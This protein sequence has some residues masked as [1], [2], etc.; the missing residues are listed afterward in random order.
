MKL[1]FK[2]TQRFVSGF[3]LLSALIVVSAIAFIIINNKFF[4]RRIL[5]KAKFADAIGLSPSTPVFFKGFKIGLITD[6]HLTTSNMIEANFE[7]YEEFEN[8]IVINSA[9]MKTVNPVTNASAIEFL[10]GEGET[11]KLSPGSLIPAIDVSEGRAL[12]EMNKVKKAGD[13]LSQLLS[14]LGEFAANLRADNNSDKGAIFRA[15]VNVADASEH[16]KIIAERAVFI[17]E[18]LLAEKSPNK[19]LLFETLNNI[20]DLT[21]EFKKTNEL[22]NKTIIRADSVLMAYQSPD[23]LGIRMV[24]PT[25]EK[26]FKPLNK[27]MTDVSSLIPKLQYLIDY[28]NTRT[29]DMTII[30]DELRTTMRQAQISFES[31]N[32]LATGGSY[33]SGLRMEFPSES[34][35][36]P[37]KIDK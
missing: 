25:G 29:A 30:L 31:F 7:V 10:Q 8:K 17:T 35:T 5:Y 14:E 21:E 3:L 36:R 2:Y 18:S 4:E 12:L 16:M 15:L 22:M 9:L 1:R 6:F 27:I 26:L 28:M 33:N 23:S 24:D 19:G 20:K 32:N 11:M 13:P 37:K 34:D